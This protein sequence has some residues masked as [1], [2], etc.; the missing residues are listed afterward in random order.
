MP[1]N[2]AQRIYHTLF[3]RPVPPLVAQRF[4]AASERLDAAVPPA[5]LAAYR[6]ALASGA[7]L[8]ALELAA[9]YTHRLPLLTRKLGL[10]AYLAETLPENQSLFINERSNWVGAI[11]ALGA[12]TLRTV[13]KMAKGLFLLRGVARA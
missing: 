5:E 9:R 12:A 6:A 2:E 13:W 1:D 7:D 3:N 8:E 11:V 10:M 4:A